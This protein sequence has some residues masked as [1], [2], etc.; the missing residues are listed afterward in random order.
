MVTGYVPIS[1]HPRSS[2]E[3]D[4]LGSQLREL[5]AASIRSFRSSL[6]ECWLYEHVSGREVDHAVSDNPTKNT[7]AYHV[8]QHQKTAWLLQALDDDPDAEVFVWLDY[9]I[10]Y[11]PGVTTAVID[12]YLRCIRSSAEIVLP[13]AWERPQGAKAHDWRSPDWHFCGSSFVVPREIVRRFHEA[14]REVTLE[15]LTTNGHLTWEINDWAEVERRQLVPMRW[16]RATHDQ[17]QFTNYPAAKPPAIPE[18]VQQPEPQPGPQEPIARTQGSNALLGLCMIVK[19]EAHGIAK[20][21]QSFAPFIDYWTIMDTGSTDNTAD[22]VR[23]T[24]RAVPGELIE[25]PFVDFSTTRNHVLAHH[26]EKTRWTLMPDADDY[27]VGGDKLRQ[28]LPVQETGIEGFMLNLRRGHL[29]YYLPLVLRSSKK[30][31]YVGRVHEN[32]DRLIQHKIAGVEVRQDQPPESREASKKRWERDARLLEEDLRGNPRNPRTLFYLAQTYEC[33]SDKPKAIELYLKRIEVGGWVDETFETHLRLASLYRASSNDV[34]ADRWLIA[35]HSLL[36]ERAEPLL[37]LAQHYHSKDSHA[38]A[39]LFSDR[40]AEMPYSQSTLWVDHGAQDECARLASI[41]GYYLKDG[42]AK[43]AGSEHAK[44]C[45]RRDPGH[46]NFRSNWAFYSRDVKRTFGG[47]TQRI[48]FTPPSGWNA[49]NPSI[50]YDSVDKLLR[51][52]VRTTNYKIVDGYYLTPD[53]NI[54]YTRN[55]ML[56]LADDLT[57]MKAVEMIDKTGIPRSPYPVHGFEDCR[58]FRIGDHLMCSS[59]VCDFDLDKPKEGPREIVAMQLSE[60]YEIA[61][62]KAIRGPWSDR[63]QKNWM[64]FEQHDREEWIYAASNNAG[65]AVRIGPDQPPPSLDH[66]RLR[67]GSQLVKLSDGTWI[68]VVHD[69]AFPGGRTRFYLHRFALFDEKA[70]RVI[71]MTDPFYFEKLGIEFCC[72]LARI[73]DRLVASFSI[74]DAS[75]H[76]AVFD[77][78]KVLAVMEDDFAI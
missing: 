64:P 74:D 39:F 15:R 23:E 29:D 76:F 48:D 47:T 37:K 66:G 25:G 46:G 63:C 54:I 65:Q 52:V 72:G 24:L 71:A 16:Y 28:Q 45:V 22:V 68:A 10:L 49:S 42:Y 33:L 14:V 67:G 56:E 5:T 31:R 59:T 58:L 73:D 50:H 17:T 43:Q 4:Q 20:T 44:D 3:Y 60:A 21:L 27:L 30:L 77:V 53:D 1:N 34:E 8:V 51:C 57:T 38:L 9:G 18:T 41:H 26:G 40:G 6:E 78:K 62:A 69:V 61:Q 55:W 70:E 12:D 13:G 75:A 19:D 2:E 32:V 35:A 36:P 7:V 11:Q